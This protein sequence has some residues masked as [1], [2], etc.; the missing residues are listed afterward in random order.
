MYIVLQV[1]LVYE[2]KVGVESILQA[3]LGANWPISMLQFTAWKRMN[4]YLKAEY[5]C[6][7]LSFQ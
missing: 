4:T 5:V 7:N 6:T 1:G 2:F 3:Q